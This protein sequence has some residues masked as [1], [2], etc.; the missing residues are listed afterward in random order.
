MR[1]LTLVLVFFCLAALVAG[2]EVG[3]RERLRKLISAAR[4]GDV[5]AR[6][7][8]RNLR[9]KLRNRIG[10][11]GSPNIE[12]QQPVV[13]IE[14]TKPFV[15]PEQV[16]NNEPPQ[17]AQPRRI[18]QRQFLQDQP[19][20]RTRPTPIE[21]DNTLFEPHRA[22]NRGL[23]VDTR[24]EANAVIR[25]TNKT[26]TPPIQTI[27]R[28]S[29]FDEQG[30]YIFG[31]EAA[32]GSFKEEKRGL[33]CIVHG[34]YGYVDPD[35]VRRE[36]TY[37]SGNRCDP[38][39]PRQDDGQFEQP[40]QSQQSQR[41]QQPRHDQFLIQ[42]QEKI[43]DPI[44]TRTRPA[45]TEPIQTERRPVSSRRRRPVESQKQQPPQTNRINVVSEKH[46]VQINQQQRIEEKSSVKQIHESQPEIPQ[47][48]SVPQ[49]QQ[50]KPEQFTP[51][52][53]PKKVVSHFQIATPQP[54][55]FR[56]TPAP[57]DFNFEKEFHNLFSNFGNQRQPI[58]SQ[59]VQ[60]SRPRIASPAPVPAPTPAPVRAPAPSP[61]PAAKP[62][63]VAV[64]EPRPANVPHQLVFDSNTGTFKTIPL[65]SFTKPSGSNTPFSSPSGVGK[66]L[67]LATG[68]NPLPPVPFGSLTFK[69][70]AGNN[71]AQFDNFFNGFHFN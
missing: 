4:G 24:S 26:R 44:K 28:F 8:L 48:Q 14:E 61:V 42:T 36:F 1:P 21:R 10:D 34:K 19:R 37:V 3:R 25:V 66:P 57:I 15:E 18:P 40:Q 33:D 53:A 41:P 9:D 11:A 58:P 63:V 50:P 56:P 65:Q 7:A 70:S 6:T 62:K 5:E 22:L 45:P 55:I 17:E 32:D 12:Q 30:N 2:Q 13:A 27:R 59:F 16:V 23:E 51:I 69:G 49:F 52:E 64:E 46:E 38:K 54:P 29:Y 60:P 43:V 71:A 31:Y 35:G 68:V 39:A 47:I 20:V 67:P